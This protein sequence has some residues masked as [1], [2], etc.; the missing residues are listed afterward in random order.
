[1]MSPIDALIEEITD[2]R[3]AESLRPSRLPVERERSAE[4]STSASPRAKCLRTRGCTAMSMNGYRL[5]G[6]QRTLVF[7]PGKLTVY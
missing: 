3:M 1:M 7:G 4:K 2:G 5:R 6:H